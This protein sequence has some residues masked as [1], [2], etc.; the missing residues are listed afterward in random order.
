MRSAPPSCLLLTCRN[1]AV[2][3]LLATAAAATANAQPRNV[4]LITIDDFRPE[5]PVYG[6]T[7]IRAPHL[8]RLSA[9]GLTFNRA[10]VQQAVCQPSRECVFTGARPDTTRIYNVFGP[11]G[12]TFRTTMGDVATLP[13]VFKDHGFWTAGFGKNFHHEDPASWTVST[14]FYET[15][16]LYQHPAHRAVAGNIRARPAWEH[17]DGPEAHYMD[18]RIAAA[19]AQAIR[20]RVSDGKRFFIAAGFYKP[21]L[22]FT[23]PKAYWDL[24]NRDTLPLPTG[25][26]ALPARD[27]LPPAFYDPY[28]GELGTYRGGRPPF[29]EITAATQA[30]V[31]DG[32]F[33][34]NQQTG[35]DYGII[36]VNGT[37]IYPEDYARALTHGYSACVSFIDA[38]IGKLLAAL[39]DP[40]NDGDKSDSILG[41]TII[42]LWGDHGMHLGR[43]GSWPKHTNMDVATRIPLIIHHPDMPA[44]TR[45]VMTDALVES[46]DIMP[47]LLE[48]TGLPAPKT[49][50]LEGRSFAPL[51]DSP[52]R[53]WK[54]AAFSQYPKEVPDR[55]GDWHMGYAMRTAT[56]SYVQW[57][58]MQS[59]DAHPI[60][61]EKLNFTIT[62]AVTH[63][64]LYDL[65][66]APHQ[67]QNI[68]TA[69][70]A[71]PLMDAYKA[72]L[73][74]AL[75]TGYANTQDVGAGNAEFQL[76]ISR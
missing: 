17:H 22:P 21:H 32:T 46:V 14:D 70:E 3:L 20:E 37:H 54:I 25:L 31:D 36:T 38:Q 57:R 27:A 15:A 35:D 58:R 23:A 75:S 52:N 2:S 64:E 12:P 62:E 47:T 53:P 7:H 69:P 4:L 33:T 16:D 76:G 73:N 8:D 9:T 41:D 5:L 29:V 40:D 30:S 65:V 13:S 26:D 55:S 74:T 48:M 18:A 6:A 28:S 50:T 72:M 44:G 60:S 67:H 71:R 19:A 10:Y 1:A 51:L 49:H 56:H 59:T 45:G 39:E 42:V 43:H 63:E 11:A 24:Y 66:N 68:G 34:T 61:L